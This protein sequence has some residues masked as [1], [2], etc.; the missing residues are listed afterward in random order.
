MM[1]SKRN[2]YHIKTNHH[3]LCIILKRLYLFIYSFIHLLIFREGKGGRKRGR[4]TSM[5]GCL[6]CT[7]LTRDLACNPGMCPDQ[8]LNQQPFALQ[9]DAQS[10]EPQQPGLML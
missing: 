3:N 8:E 10:I 5:C 4:G 1:I 9:S 2:A 7:P 6:L